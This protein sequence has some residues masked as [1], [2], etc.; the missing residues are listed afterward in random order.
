[1][2]KRYGIWM[3]M[4]PLFIGGWNACQSSGD[5]GKEEKGEQQIDLDQWRQQGQ[6]YSMKAQQA[7]GKNLKAALEK[8]GP[9]YA[10]DFCHIE[11]IP[12]TDSAAMDMDVSLKRVSEKYRNPDNKANEKE[13][14]YI[15]QAKKQLAAGETI[16]PSI[17]K[18]DEKIVGYYP[19][20]TNEMCMNCHGQ[21]GKDIKPETL[22]KIGELYP[23]DLAV[24]YRPHEVRG[25]WVVEMDSERQDK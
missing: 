12:I 11:A 15:A 19:I 20:I 5:S 25:I 1:M 10:L 17:D 6:E 24:G 22:A 7:L 4:I 21:P 2:I 9:V 8:G 14:Q 13:A 23:D 18:M 3:L 16:E